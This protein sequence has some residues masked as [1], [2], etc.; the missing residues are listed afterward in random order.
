MVRAQ[1]R[2]KVRATTQSSDGAGTAFAERFGVAAQTFY[3]RRNR[4]S[5]EDRSHTPHRLQ[6]TL[7]PAQEAACIAG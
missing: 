2:T 5:V 1:W 4:D 7:T 3:K 6:M